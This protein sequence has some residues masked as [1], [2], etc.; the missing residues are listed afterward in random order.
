MTQFDKFW[1]G[2]VQRV[3]KL[4]DKD[5]S[6]NMDLEQFKKN[7]K[8]AFDAGFEAHK[9]AVKDYEK[10]TNKTSSFLDKFFGLTK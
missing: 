9:E 2:L 1:A 7:M 5:L 3:P 6:L 10:L 8:R 4:A